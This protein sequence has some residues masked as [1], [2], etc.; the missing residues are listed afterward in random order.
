MRDVPAPASSPSPPNSGRH[1]GIDWLRIG[2]FHLL[3]LYHI[4]M[5]FVPWEWHVSSEQAVPWAILPMV[6]IN[7]WRLTLL[8]A[9]SGF[10]SASMLAR[11]PDL[12]FFLRNR[13]VRLGVPL[14]FGI[15]VITPIQPWIQLTT[16]RGY[17][18]GFGWF[19]LH[20]YYRFA[21]F[22]GMPL[23]A[24]Q[25]L[26]FVFYL[27]AYTLLLVALLLL[28]AGTRSLA[29]RAVQTILTGPL[30]VLLPIAIAVL[31]RLRW[32]PQA[33]D[34]HNFLGDWV[35]HIRHIPAF[36]FG[37]LLFASPSFWRTIRRGL[38]WIAAL[39]LASTALAVLIA[40][41]YPMTRPITPAMRTLYQATRVVQGWTGLLALIG[42][43]D[44]FWNRD[45]P[46]RATLAEAVF[47]FYII[48]QTIIIV[49]GWLLLSSGASNFVQL[50]ILIFATI[51][52][53]W[54]FYLIGRRIPFV[55]PL[56]GLRPL[57]ERRSAEERKVA[58]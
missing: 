53:C 8:F 20:D 48:H 7:A 58:A 40:W 28:P 1:Y 46:W 3:I 30:L 43:A 17:T 16:Q 47:P 23:P 21:M 56:I 35:A 31:A 42:V 57:G 54:L 6:A 41:D 26:W 33:E 45:R 12:A 9:V 25:H 39:A 2:A 38:P 36:L 51:V 49:V 50:L 11:R 10:A 44:R 5:V 34:N 27:L 22:K 4:G 32:L 55:R 18:H 19:Y 24:W 37:Y 14:L 52:G 29:R 13:V 15:I